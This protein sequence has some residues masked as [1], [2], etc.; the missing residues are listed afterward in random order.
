MIQDVNHFYLRKE[1]DYITLHTVYMNNSYHWLR[2]S[3]LVTSRF[4]FY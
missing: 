4:Y 2:A 1:N 3:V